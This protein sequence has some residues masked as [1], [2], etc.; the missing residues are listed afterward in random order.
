[1]VFVKLGG[2]P[3]VGPRVGLVPATDVLLFDGNPPG[4]RADASPT[5]EKKWRSRVYSDRITASYCSRLWFPSFVP[6][7]VSVR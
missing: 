1:M 2:S 6:F 7:I 3:A 4:A 5:H